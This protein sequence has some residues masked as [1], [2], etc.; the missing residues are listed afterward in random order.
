MLH[1][2]Q[3]NIGLI[4][5]FNF[6][7][8]LK[9]YQALGIVVFAAIAGNYTLGMAVFSTIAVSSALFELPT[10]VLSDWIGRKNTMIIGAL[11]SI[12]AVLFFA[13]ASDFTLLGIGGVFYGLALSFFSGNNSA[14]LFDTLKAHDKLSLHHKILGYSHATGYL[15][16]AVSALICALIIY[17]SADLKLLLWLT[18]L[19]QI[20]A[21]FVALVITDPKIITPHRENIKHHLKKA[22]SLFYHNPK[23]KWLTL[24]FIGDCSVGYAGY[25]MITAFVNTLIPTWT[26]GI[27]EALFCTFG[28][29]GAYISS[30]I[31]KVTGYLKGFVLGV[32][33]IG[34]LRICSIFAGAII[35][36]ILLIFSQFIYAV[37]D[38]SQQHLLQME[39]TDKERAT[40]GSITSLISSIV[41]A[42]VSLLIG[43]LA[44]LT[45]VQTALIIVTL[46]WVMRIFLFKKALKNP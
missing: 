16:M 5:L 26:V 46:I 41:W 20:L 45:N 8:A 37:T 32:L 3:R 13:L 2:L 25:E 43:W 4:F 38:A 22:V 10:G 31:I 6:L 27:Y 42:I 29:I 17:L 30:A 36:P 21:F 40:I 12:L 11:C 9:F 7:S 15:G 24:S 14:I 39:Y 34:I 18:L 33:L 35:A 44:D 1:S 23:A 28:G 19:P